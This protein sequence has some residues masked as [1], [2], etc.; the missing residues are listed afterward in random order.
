M[1]QW[2]VIPKMTKKGFKSRIF[3]GCLILSQSV[4]LS[5]KQNMESVMQEKRSQQTSL[6]IYPAQDK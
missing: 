3:Q 5:H 4:L 1:F 2:S 6:Q